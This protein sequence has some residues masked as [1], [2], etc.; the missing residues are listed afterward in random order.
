[1]PAAKLLIE[2][3]FLRR[4]GSPCVH[5]HNASDGL[6]PLCCLFVDTGTGCGLV[7]R[8]QASPC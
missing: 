1:M 5:A 7:E 4:A 8:A 3:Y 6:G 2:F